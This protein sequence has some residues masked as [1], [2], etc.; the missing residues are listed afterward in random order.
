MILCISKGEMPFKMYKKILEN[1]LGRVGTH[2]FIIVV[3][4]WKKYDFMH[5]E[6]QNAFQNA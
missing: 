1:F 5:F 2:I 4:F 6:R 3:F